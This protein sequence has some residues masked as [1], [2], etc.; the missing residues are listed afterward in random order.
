MVFPL[1]PPFSHGFPMVFLDDHGRILKKNHQPG[2][3]SERSL[4]SADSLG[5]VAKNSK[6]RAL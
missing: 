2:G 1:K 3:Q 4:A 6:N 5:E